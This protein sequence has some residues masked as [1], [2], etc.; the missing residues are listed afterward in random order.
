M[1]VHEYPALPGAMMPAMVSQ[2]GAEV[3]GGVADWFWSQVDRGSSADGCWRWTGALHSS[4]YGRFHGK[5][6]G[7]WYAHR[8]AW[9]LTYGAIR[10]GLQIMHRCEDR[11]CVR[12]GHLFAATMAEAGR[13]KAAHDL[14][15]RGD[16]SAAHRYPE[17]RPRGERHGAAKL[18]DAQAVAIRAR[19]AAREA[20]ITRLAAEYG[21]STTQVWRIVTGRN[22][23]PPPTSRPPRAE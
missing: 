19:Y 10:P 23:R 4:G 6:G 7:E 1:G 9:V 21:V 2:D 3:A 15:A 18:T 17:R 11:L 8:L 12:P 14:F 16:R 13:Y 20:S 22:R 5:A